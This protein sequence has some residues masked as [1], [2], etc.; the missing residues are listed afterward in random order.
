MQTKATVYLIPT[1]LVDDD[2]M[3]MACLPQYIVDAIKK[4]E[5]FFVENERTTRRFFK[6]I[7]RDMVIDHYAWHTIHKAEAHVQNELRAAIKAQKSIGIVSEAGCPAI[8]DPG[9]YLVQ[10]A[11]QC[12]ATVKPLVGPTSIMLALMASGLNG[13]QFTFHGYLP[14]E[15]D[16]RIAAIKSLE[17][18]VQIQQ[19][20]EIF[21]ETPYRNNQLLEAIL[22][23]C[24]ATTMLCIAVNLTGTEELVQTK[25]IRSWKKENIDLHKKPVIFILG[26]SI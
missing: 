25:S 14:I 9:A 15:N 4:C 24:T 8:A 1:V 19:S 5:V 26:A 6:K 11:H 20:A 3:G 13:Q 17:K 21:I 2:E 22:T 10:V 23:Y 18:K 7:W 12:G 16:K